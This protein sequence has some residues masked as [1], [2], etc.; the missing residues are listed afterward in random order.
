MQPKCVRRKAACPK[1]KPHTVST[2]VHLMA[3]GRDSS[4]PIIVVV[5]HS[6]S[7]ACAGIHGQP[8]IGFHDSRFTVLL[9][10]YDRG[11]C[12]TV[13][14]S[15]RFIGLKC[16]TYTTGCQRYGIN[17]SN[18]CSEISPSDGAPKTLMKNVKVW[19]TSA[20]VYFV[21][22]SHPFIRLPNDA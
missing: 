17:N 4:L 8:S 14:M 3:N 6:Q 16:E 12:V 15:E 20:W 13:Q 18:E 19:F 2:A 22:T 7:H 10:N 5:G 21:C 1:M 11:Y 9:L